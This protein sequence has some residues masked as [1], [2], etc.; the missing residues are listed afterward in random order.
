MMDTIQ[1]YQMENFSMTKQDIFRECKRRSDILIATTLPEGCKNKEYLFMAYD[2]DR[3][4][5]HGVGL[6]WEDEDGIVW[7]NKE[8]DG[9]VTDNYLLDTHDNILCHE[10]DMNDN[11]IMICEYTLDYPLM[12]KRDMNGE[13]LQVNHIYN[14]ADGRDA[15][16]MMPKFMDRLK[17]IQYP[18]I[19]EIAFYGEKP[20]ADIVENL[21]A[22]IEIDF[23][24]SND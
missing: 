6:Y 4:H 14:W 16:A 1:V 11:S 20:Y 10:V 19:D 5:V 22:Y 12:H 17:E 15:P 24:L 3:Q 2:I 8:V 7:G 13:I 9:V 18:C 21:F 23:E